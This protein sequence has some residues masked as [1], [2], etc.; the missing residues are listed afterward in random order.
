[1]AN[2]ELLMAEV[3]LLEEVLLDE[4]DDE[5]ELDVVIEALDCCEDTWLDELDVLTSL[6]NDISDVVSEDC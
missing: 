2:D 5:Y 3:A 6:D 4:L 1:M